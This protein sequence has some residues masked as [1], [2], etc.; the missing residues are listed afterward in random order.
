MTNEK[1]EKPK[2]KTSKKL[3]PLYDVQIRHKDNTT[4][5]TFRYNGVVRYVHVTER[6]MQNPEMVK[7]ADGIFQGPALT[8]APFGIEAIVDLQSTLKDQPYSGH[9]SAFLWAPIADKPEAKPS[10]VWLDSIVT[11]MIAW[12]KQGW[13]ILVHCT[14]GLSRSSLITIAYFMRTRG[15]SANQALDFVKSKKADINPNTGFIEALNEYQNY[16]TS[17]S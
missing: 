15:Y 7:L 1:T 5:K 16:L 8:H 10:L 6:I 17:N 14:A 2:I 3:G 9:L 4:I 11:T 13:S 12:R